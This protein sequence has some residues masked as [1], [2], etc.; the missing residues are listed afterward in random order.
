M[1]LKSSTIMGRPSSSSSMRLL[2]ALATLA[3]L[4]FSMSMAACSGDGEVLATYEGGEITRGDM[5]NLVKASGQNPEEITTA[6]Q[7]EILKIIATY[8]L[9]ALEMSGDKEVQDW[10]KANSGLLERKA[11]LR[12]FQAHL[13]TDEPFQI[14][15]IQ[16]AI[17]RKDQERS[18][19]KEAEDL[20]AKLN[21]MSSDDEI[22]ALVA[23]ASDSEG[24]RLNGGRIVPHCISCKPDLL[25]FVTDPLKEAEQ[26][27][28]IVIDAEGAYYVARKLS[29]D[30]LEPEELF[31][32]YQEYFTSL[33]K[34][35]KKAGLEKEISPVMIET[36]AKQYS[37]RL[38]RSQV[39]SNEELK[40]HLEKIE[41]EHEFKINREG[42]SLE[43]FN[44][45]ADDTWIMEMD[46]KKRTIADMKKI[47]DATSLPAEALVQIMQNIYIPSELLML[48]PE[49][50]SVVDSD[51]YQFMSEYNKNE[52]LA[53]R[54]MQKQTENMQVT[55]EQIQEYYN[56]RKFN[57]F[58]G[59]P[60]ATVREG[61]RQQLQQSN[62]QTAVQT[63]RDNLFKKYNLSIEREK[64]ESGEI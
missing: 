21:E 44:G 16:L 5:R 63:V 45:E 10:I 26:G 49:Y 22:D 24:T 37:D 14:I 9:A 7:N 25:S 40:E 50:D 56:L 64:L 46:G 17:V 29:L 35:A 2:P 12:A 53:G 42:L 20:A 60:L 47:V 3:V 61:I 52:A 23:Q 31:A 30:E 58:Q 43:S 11:L 59:K 1:R 57:Q 8:R 28:F 36:Q 41:K 48:S 54:Y 19:K 13:K 38:V 4:L 18:R 6:Q 34:M 39:N 62:S 32:F 51:L 27:K 55:E 33:A 15:S